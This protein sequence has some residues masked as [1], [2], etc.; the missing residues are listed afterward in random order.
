MLLV[1]YGTESSS[2]KNYWKL[3]NSW[4]AEWGQQGYLYIV[5]KGDGEG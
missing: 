5:R 3:K 4:G 1:G 2:K